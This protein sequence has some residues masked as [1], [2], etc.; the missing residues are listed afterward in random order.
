MRGGLQSL[1]WDGILHNFISWLVSSFRSQ[2][3]K[4]AGLIEKKTL[5]SDLG[6]TCYLPQ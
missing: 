5:T 2:T 3:L 6:R 1:G 4:L